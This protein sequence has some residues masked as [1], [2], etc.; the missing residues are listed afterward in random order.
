MFYLIIGLII[1][2]LI[3]IACYFFMN[4]TGPSKFKIIIV[5]VFNSKIGRS[6]SSE[7]IST[8]DIDMNAS[9]SE[10]KKKKQ[11]PNMFKV[12][13][14]IGKTKLIT[15]NHLKNFYSNIVQKKSAS[16]TELPKLLQR[17]HSTVGTDFPKQMVKAAKAAKK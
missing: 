12:F 4:N 11:K 7:E 5:Q 17:R 16:L 14:C 10:Q 13:S 15:T 2:L 3:T 1:I 9:L 8:D 6:T